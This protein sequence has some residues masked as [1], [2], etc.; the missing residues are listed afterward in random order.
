MKIKKENKSFV[1][2]YIINTGK[3]DYTDKLFRYFTTSS[4]F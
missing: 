2:N 1:L 3:H 4:F